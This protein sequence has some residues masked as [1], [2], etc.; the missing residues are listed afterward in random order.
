M[1][2]RSLSLF[3]V[4]SLL[5]GCAS[6]YTSQP[7]AP[8]KVGNPPS[9]L[10]VEPQP[11]SEETP[12]TSTEKIPAT[13][14]DTESPRPA[15]P[16][17][18]RYR[19]VHVGRALLNQL[20]PPKIGDRAGWAQDIFGAFE[21]LKIPY[22]KEYFCA[23]IATI[24]QESSWQA[25]PVVPG[26]N[27]MVWEQIGNK[28][29]KYGLPLP[30]VKA[31]LGRASGNGR[32]YRDRI[33][34]LRTE[35][36]MNLLFE[37]MSAEAERLG[38]PLNMQNP[39]RTGGPMQVSVDFATG[40]T[41]AW[42]YPYTYKGSL[43]HEVFTRRGGTYFGVANLLHYRA[44][45]TD[46]AFRFADY[47]AGRFSS[48]NAA[49][50]A[51]VARLGKIKLNRDGDLLRYEAGRPSKTPSN[52]QL[53]LRDLAVRIKMSPAEIERDLLLEKENAFEQTPLYKRVFDQVDG[54]TGEPAPRAIF[55]QIRLSSPK[56]THK[57]TTEWFAKRV[58]GRYRT[59]LARG[60]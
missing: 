3:I 43:R 31:A 48:R 2:L 40:H 21:G 6:T 44:P 53:A 52:T 29:D 27:R 34:S 45:Y 50:Q 42:P 28:A 26:L 14:P 16:T 15:T 1:P 56:I 55:P 51:A 32:S 4:G 25:D 36:Q 57:L 5:A 60:T 39:I 17:S 30:V 11:T 8:I 13:V 59:C 12:P 7:T 10:P 9:T 23:A 46:M 41:K 24:E 19:D 49:F 38:L 22:T 47:N 33:D 18:T 54:Q 58:D 37:E 35:T 20:L